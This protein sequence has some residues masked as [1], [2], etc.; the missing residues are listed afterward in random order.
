MQQIYLT[1]PNA[2]QV[3]ARLFH[4]LNVHPAGFT[5]QPFTING[6][7]AGEALH[8]LTQP[9]MRCAN[10]VPFRIRLSA[11]G[12]ADE[13][14][15]ALL[16]EAL[17]RIAAPSLRQV[18]GIGVPLLLGQLDA[19]MLGCEAF[20]SAVKRALH[21]GSLCVAV[22][23]ADAEQALRRAT[24]A[25]SQLW[26][27]TADPDQALSAALDEAIQRIRFGT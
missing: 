9:P 18:T 11:S 3:S 20:F 10:D 26:L 12:K 2:A 5:V 1:G 7:T 15:T 25:D 6:R 27:D 4:G 24:P 21:G 19:E 22:V 13:V 16:P 8:L 14:E 17:A 23:A